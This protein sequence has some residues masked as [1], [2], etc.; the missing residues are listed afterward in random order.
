MGT[1]DFG[2]GTLTSAGDH[3]I[4]VAKFGPNGDHL[5]S[6]R[7]GDADDQDGYSIAVDGSGNVI[8]MGALEGTVDFGGGALTSAGGYDIVVAK[9]GSDGAHLWSKRF[10]DAGLQEPSR[11]AVDDSGN[12]VATGFFLGAID[13]GGGALTSAGDEDVFVAK[14]GPDGAHLWSKR[15]G[16]ANIQKAYGIAVDASGNVIVTGDFRGTVDF[17]GGALTSA[18]DYDVFVVKLGSDG[19]H[20]WSKRFGDADI[21]EGSCV[22]VDALGSV[23]VTGG[24]HGSVNFGGGA[25]TSAGDYDVFVAKLGSDGAHRWSKRFGD[26]D[27]QYPWAVA[28]DASRNVT[29]AGDLFGSVNFGG[30][31]LTSAGADDIFVARFGK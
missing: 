29:V 26:A 5:W 8:I 4:Y 12:V 10:G 14:F 22:A 30:G 2:G 1:V 17:G 31:V 18:G 23:I 7:F 27:Y 28:V 15:F 13:L 19:A 3:D 24:F 25:L 9:F 6:K 21:Q 20:R 16:D 11:V